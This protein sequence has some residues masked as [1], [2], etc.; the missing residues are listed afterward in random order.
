MS[1]PDIHRDILQLKVY[2]EDSDKKIADLLGI[3][4]Q[5]VRKRLQR[6]RNALGKLLKERGGN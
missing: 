6:A 4:H 5:A 3:S 1:L 2:Y